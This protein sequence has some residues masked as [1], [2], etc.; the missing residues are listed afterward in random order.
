MF[1]A[2]PNMTEDK[3]V[4]DLKNLFGGKGEH[5]SICGRAKA[6]WMSV[7]AFVMYRLGMQLNGPLEEAAD[8]K[9]K[10]PIIHPI[11][12]RRRALKIKL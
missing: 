5:S 10:R 2:D 1:V 7:L 12:I 11:R 8:A 6:H 3:I 4:N 9:R